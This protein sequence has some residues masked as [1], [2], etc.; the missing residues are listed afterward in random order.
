MFCCKACA[1]KERHIAYLQGLLDRTLAMIA[2]KTEGAEALKV[3]ED[4][5]PIREESLEVVR[6]GEE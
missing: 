2:P 6:Y 5:E 4:V 3:T 1:A